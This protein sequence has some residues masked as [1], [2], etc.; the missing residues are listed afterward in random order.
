VAAPCN[1]ETHFLTAYG[2]VFLT[3]IWRDDAS[4]GLAD[5]TSLGRDVVHIFRRSSS[6]SSSSNPR[7]EAV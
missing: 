1:E 7:G 3:P 5:V 2:A 6:S 4:R